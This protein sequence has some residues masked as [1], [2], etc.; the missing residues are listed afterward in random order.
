MGMKHVF[1]PLFHPAQV[2]LVNAHLIADF[3]LM[4]HTSLLICSPSTFCFHA[5]LANMNG[6]VV[7]PAYGPWVDFRALPHTSVSNSD[8]TSYVLA[9]GSA[10][11]PP[12]HVLIDTRR[13][14]FHCNGM[15][16][17]SKMAPLAEYAAELARYLVAH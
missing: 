5:A 11:L 15:H 17:P 3:D 6:L 8:N 9:E 2:K 4:V 7:L 12:N 16:V 10:L 14:G 13:A 1:E